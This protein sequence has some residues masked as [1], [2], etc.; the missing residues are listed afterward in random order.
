MRTKSVLLVGHQLPRSSGSLQP[1]HH[2]AACLQKIFLYHQAFAVRL[3]I[4]QLCFLL[5]L[6]FRR[7]CCALCQAGSLCLLK[8]LPRLA[9]LCVRLLH[10]F[11]HLVLSLGELWV[12]VVLRARLQ[13]VLLAIHQVRAK[14]IVITVPKLLQRTAVQ[15]QF[16]RNPSVHCAEIMHCEEI[17]RHAWRS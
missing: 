14:L 2:L 5:Q 3:Q 4:R 8:L 12:Q 11:P 6:L 7:L 1:A 9:Y 16:G 15:A 17:M 13:L 10:L